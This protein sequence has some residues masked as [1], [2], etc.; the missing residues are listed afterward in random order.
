VI[1]DAPWRVVLVSQIPRVA[2]QYAEQV[3]SLGHEPVAH[4]AARFPKRFDSPRLHEFAGRLLTEGPHDVD[5]VFPADRAQLAKVLRW[6]EPDLLLCT[7]FPWRIPPDALAIPK[8][9]CV[10]GHPSLLPKHRGPM[11]MAWAIRMGETEIGMTYHLM[12]DQFDT[13]NILAQT[14]VP[15]DDDETN[16]SLWPKLGAA[17]AELLPVV[18]EKL[19]RGDRGDPQKGGDY[20]SLFDDDYAFV[21]TSRAA[22]DVHRQVRAWRFAFIGKNERGPILERD[23]ERLRIVKTSLTEVAG[24]ERLDCADR[25]IWIVETE[26]VTDVPA[27]S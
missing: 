13:G 24:A 3:R 8:I 1:P 11:P 19:A 20:Q 18:F 14:S 2:L 10:N 22:E 17:S 5:L 21:D 25:P 15:L 12:E 27:G 16:E 7:A 23:G 6:Y 9:A 4:L 26:P